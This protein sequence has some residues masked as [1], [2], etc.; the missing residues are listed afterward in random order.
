MRPELDF[1]NVLDAAQAG[2]EWAFDVLFRHYQPLLLRY[3]RAQEPVAAEDLASE[4]WM[5][6]ATRIGSFRGDEGGFRGWL[7]TVAR[8][9]LIEHRRQAARRRTD[10]VPAHGLA[11][12]AAP[13][14]PAAE[15][16]AALAT[17]EAVERLVARLVPD[18][19]E[20]V[21]LRVVAG[22]SVAEVA[23]ITGHSPGSVRMLQHRALNRL[24]A[25]IPKE[26]VT[27]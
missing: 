4:V 19:A 10:P 18:Q 9:R 1:P 20:V 13:D 17:Q 3:L 8:R 7:F 27:T 2:G 25:T 14:D 12:R 6:L 26:S 23:E 5:A 15:V 24:A 16:G 11:S 21:L 22:L